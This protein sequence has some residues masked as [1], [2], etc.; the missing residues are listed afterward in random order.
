ITG[1]RYCNV[2]VTQ[3]SLDRHVGNSETMQIRRK[4]TAECMPTVPAGKHNIALILVI[5]ASAVFCLWLAANPTDIQCRKNYAAQVAIRVYSLSCSI[6]E[7]R[8]G[9]R[10]ALALTMFS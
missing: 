7:H 6:Q 1:L 8:P 5:C 4:T 2:A 3:D 9:N 10:V